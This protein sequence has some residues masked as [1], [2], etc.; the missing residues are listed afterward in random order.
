MS[1]NCEVCGKF[2]EIDET[3]CKKHSLKFDFYDPFDEAHYEKVL[4]HFKVKVW[5]AYEPMLGGRSYWGYSWKCG[6]VQLCPEEYLSEK[7]ARAAS[8]LAIYLYC[9]GVGC[10]LDDRLALA[11]I[12]GNS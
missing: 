2:I 5:S 12:K 9:C 6:G 4:S 7:M 3:L 8:A 1:N 10:S 11:Y